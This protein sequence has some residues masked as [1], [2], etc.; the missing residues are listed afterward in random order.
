MFERLQRVIAG[1][2]PE[3]CINLLDFRVCVIFVCAVLSIGFALTNV[4]KA[5]KGR[6]AASKRSKQHRNGGKTLES[7]MTKV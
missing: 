1:I 3:R 7:E 4:W 2:S 6:Q 5:H